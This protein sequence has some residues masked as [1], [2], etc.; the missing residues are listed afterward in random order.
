MRPPP[1]DDIR[2]WRRAMRDV[3]PLLGRPPRH[4]EPDRGPPSRI[5]E[6]ARETA[7]VQVRA[8]PPRPAPQPAPPLDHFAGIDRPN[9]ER[10]KRG[11][12]PIEARLDLHGLTQ[13]EAHLALARFVAGSRVAGRR[14]VLV[15]TGHGRFSGGIL[16]EAVPRWLH[17]AELRRHVLAIAPA[18][19]QHGGTGALY[20]LLRRSRD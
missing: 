4:H 19:P 15:I 13:I 8:A 2:L 20:V 14:C 6:A 18:Q 3:A 9:A 16:K 10:L 1:P 12:R 5:I 11:R 17:E 7:A